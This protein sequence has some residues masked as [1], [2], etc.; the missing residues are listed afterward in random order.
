MN[1]PIDANRYKTLM[2]SESEAVLKKSNEMVISL[3]AEIAKKMS[4]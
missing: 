1:F 2:T 4:E 3:R